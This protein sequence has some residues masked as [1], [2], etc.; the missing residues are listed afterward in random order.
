RSSATSHIV[1][2]RLRLR[3]RGRCGR[4]LCGRFL[5]GLLREGIRASR[6]GASSFLQ[7]IWVSCCA[8]DLV[9]T[10]LGVLV[11]RS[12]ELSCEAAVVGGGFDCAGLIP[13]AANG[14]P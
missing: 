6:C 3:R 5:Y 7:P 12:H 11:A 4:I 2:L 1:A 9:V 10:L 14:L 8:R 13:A